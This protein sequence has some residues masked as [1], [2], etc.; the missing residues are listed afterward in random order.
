MQPF[1]SVTV[2]VA[3]PGAKLVAVAPVFP[4]D[5]RKVSGATPPVALTVA[6]PLFWLKQVILVKFEIDADGAP[7]LFIKI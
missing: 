5:Q 6:I 1:P 2:T 7:T 4:F 3:K